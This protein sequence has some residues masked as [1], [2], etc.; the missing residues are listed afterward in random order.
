MMGTI[1]ELVQK[2]R[3]EGMVPGTLNLNK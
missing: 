1:E 3:D 2:A